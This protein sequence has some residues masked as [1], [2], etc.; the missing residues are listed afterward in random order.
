MKGRRP[1]PE[2]R[3]GPDAA[4][5]PP[6]A[7]RTP[8]EERDAL[9]AYA[10]RALGQRALSAQELRARLERRSTD[11]DLVEDILT[12]VQELGYQNDEQVARVEGARRGVGAM[13]VRQTLKR[14]GVS[15]DLIRDTVSARDPDDEVQAVQA[16][17]ARRWSSFARKRDPQASAFSFLA[18]RGYPGSVIWPVIRAF[19]AEL[20]DVPDLPDELP[21]D[22]ED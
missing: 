13:R 21:D 17:L 10:F 12:R 9:L 14:R 5:T 20:P 8:Q 4:P 1:R 6:R 2:A 18:R 19:V 11:L 22:L 15:E 7:P 16:L 3:T